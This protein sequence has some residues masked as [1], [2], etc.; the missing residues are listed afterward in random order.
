VNVESRAFLGG[1]AF[2][3]FTILLAAMLLNALGLALFGASVLRRSILVGLVAVCVL[4]LGSLDG[5]C[6]WIETASIA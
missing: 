2:N 5:W 6:S 4:G 3:F 1:S